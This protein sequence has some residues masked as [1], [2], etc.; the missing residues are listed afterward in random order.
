MLE[1]FMDVPA[2]ETDPSYYS[3]WGDPRQYTI[4]DLGMGEC[5]GEV[6]SHAQ[7]GFTHAETV[8]FEAQLLLDAG[9]YRAADEKAYQAMLIAARTLVQLQWPDVPGENDIIVNEFAT[10]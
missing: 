8:A 6:V 3:D 5:A 1:G 9:N 7:F 4:G 10:R 2:F